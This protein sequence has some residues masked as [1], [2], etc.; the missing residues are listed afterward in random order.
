MKGNVIGFD[1]DTNTGAISGH[2]GRRYEFVTLD[3]RDHRRPHHGDPVDFAP[4]GQRATQIYVLE[5]E[6]VPPSFGQFYFS[7]RGRMSRSQYW[8][9]FFLPV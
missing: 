6:Y 9:K 7:T 3:W 5:P 8:L 1:A 2:D 4:D